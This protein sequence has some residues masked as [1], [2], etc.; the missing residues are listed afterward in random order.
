MTGVLLVNMGSPLSRKEMRQFLFNMFSD[1]A[2]LPFPFM[3]RKILA[4]II[5]TFR[6]RNSWK[7]Y[8]LI[9][10]SKLIDSMNQL[11]MDL[12]KALGSD[13][14]VAT[15]YSYSSPSIL[16]AIKTLREQ[17]IT[18]FK[19]ISMYP[20]S[21]FSTTESVKVDVE[22]ASAKFKGV[23]ISILK[24][25]ADHPDFISYWVELIE[26]TI[27][28]NNFKNPTLLFSAHAVPTYQIENGDT[29]V[30]ETNLSAKVIAEKLG[31]KYKVSF[32]SK[33][34]KVKWVGPDTKV[35]LK[36]MHSE[37]TEEI[38]LVPISF[39]NENLE[40]AY[41]QDIEII[42]YAK[43]ELGIKKICRV[44]LPQ[45]HPLLIS[46]FCHLLKEESK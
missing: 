7:K 8:E 2:I 23:H 21:S 35:C 25:Y 36:T 45:T 15:A 43:N 32:Q 13:F 4:F 1:K 3:Q 34:G 10:G 41:D 14:S 6:Y 30:E 20:Q 46:T 42:P 33:I 38:V 24:T 16:Q 44:S 17:G 29:Y 12:S 22:K 37:E 19:I 31:L 40:T 5:S 27:K 9:G 39:I 18:D 11:K 26:K 28:E